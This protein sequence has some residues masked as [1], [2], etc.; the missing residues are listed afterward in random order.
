MDVSKEVCSET[1]NDDEV[2]LA[3]LTKT[4]KCERCSVCEGF[5]TCYHI[6]T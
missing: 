2:C 5:Q 4:L 6:K 3:K 1:I